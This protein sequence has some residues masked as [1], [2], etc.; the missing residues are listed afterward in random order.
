[1]FSAV[2][3]AALSPVS[4]VAV[5]FDLKGPGDDDAADEAALTLN[6]SDVLAKTVALM[7]PPKIIDA[8]TTDPNISLRVLLM[9]ESSGPK[10]KTA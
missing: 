6:G 4:C 2:S 1:L 5:S 9:P 7:T 3:W 8:T 10:L